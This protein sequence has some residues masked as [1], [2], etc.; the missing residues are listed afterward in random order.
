MRA[1][2][3]TVET[4]QRAKKEAGVLIGSIRELCGTRAGVRGFSCQ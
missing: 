1:G 4:I 2:D 3:I